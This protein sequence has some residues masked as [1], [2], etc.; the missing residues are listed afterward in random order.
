[1]NPEERVSRA[2]ELSE[3]GAALAEENLEGA[4]EAF[5]ASRD[6]LVILGLTEIAATVLMQA[7]AAARHHEDRQLALRLCRRAAED[8]PEWA[9]P[10]STMALVETELALIHTQR[11]ELAKA[12][13]FFGRAARH[14]R[15]AARLL[16]REDPSQVETERQ[17]ESFVRA[18]RGAILAMVTRRSGVQKRD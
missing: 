1:V 9:D 15:L 6:E 13:L 18:R 8:D 7:V 10:P 5:V 11:D 4:V 2:R 17:F 14:H 3:R 12:I 16:E